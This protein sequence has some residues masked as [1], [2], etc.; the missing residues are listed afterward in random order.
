MVNLRVSN[1]I[2]GQTLFGGAIV[3]RRETTTRTVLEHGKTFMISGI[4]REEKREIIRRIPG[5]GDIPGLGELFKHRELADVNSELLIFLTPY[6]VGP[7]HSRDV[8]ESEPKARMET[9]MRALGHPEKAAAGHTL[10][11]TPSPEET[12]APPAEPVVPPTPQQEPV[13]PQGG[14]IETTVAQ[15]ADAQAAK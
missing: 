9:E 7:G 6:V 4:L 11:L 10:P 14:E 13:Q 1:V 2:P 5:L 15:P 3:N 12:P 8:I